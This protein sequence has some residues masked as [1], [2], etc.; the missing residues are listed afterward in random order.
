MAKKQSK[1]VEQKAYKLVYED[2]GV[3]KGSYS[4]IPSKEDAPLI[5]RAVLEGK[6]PAPAPTPVPTGTIDIT[7]NGLVNVTDYAQA[8]VN[9][10]G[11]PEPTGAAPTVTANAENI[12]IKDYA[13]VTVAVPQPSGTIQI[14]QNTFVDVKN[15]AYANV[16]VPVSS[17]PQSVDISFASSAI[18]DSTPTKAAWLES[19]Y[20]DDDWESFNEMHVET[21]WDELSPVN[22]LVLPGTHRDLYGHPGDYFVIGVAGLPESTKWWD[23][24]LNIIYSEYNGSYTAEEL[25][26]MWREYF[27]NYS[28]DVY[29]INGHQVGKVSLSSISV[30]CRSDS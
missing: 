23:L 26:Q 29:D 11:Y 20:I 27:Y 21:S 14:T 10:A 24:E 7:E 16:N 8:N 18:A 5:E 13:T 9:V 25:E 1:A 12:N 6:K 17:E 2:Q 15:Y 19:N 22:V 30:E 3:L 4:G 28:L